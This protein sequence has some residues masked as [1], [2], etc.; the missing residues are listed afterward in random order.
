MTNASTLISTNE[1]RA[2][3]PPLDLP[4]PWAWVW[5]S[6][7]ILAL[8][9]AIVGIWYWRR[10]Q[11]LRPA[12]VVVIPPHVRA[13]QKLAEAWPLLPDPDRFC[14]HVSHTLRSYLEERYGLHAPERT[15][16][17]FLLE[18]QASRFLNPT[19]KESLQNFLRSCDLVKFARFEPTET[20]LRDLHDAALRLVD[21]TQYDQ[22][23]LAPANSNTN[24]TPQT[25]QTPPA[26]P[27]VPPSFPATPPIPTSNEPKPSVATASATTPTPPALPP[28]GTPPPLS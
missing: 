9:A 28:S 12:P 1:L 20:V 3:K 26:P 4:N 16:D 23:D 11:R 14:T 22:F 6:L 2:I 15:T 24:P 10:Q 25:R 8:A 13:R 5:W 7:G 18:L 27:E 19:Q 21:E 17:E